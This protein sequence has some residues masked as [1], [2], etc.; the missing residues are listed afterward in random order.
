MVNV[1]EKT[2]GDKIKG[3][4]NQIIVGVIPAEWELS[5]IIEFYQG[6]GDSLKRVATMSLSI[7]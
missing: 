1:T 3:L 6:K 7:K 4:V 5:T 2:G